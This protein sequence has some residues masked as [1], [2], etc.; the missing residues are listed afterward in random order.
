MNWV[1]VKRFS[2]TNDFEWTFPSATLRINGDYAN[3]YTVWLNRKLTGRTSCV[4]SVGEG[5]AY[6]FAK[7]KKRK[8]KIYTALLT[9]SVK[10]NT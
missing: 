1:V 2:A 6:G 5:F 9:A 10:T 7:K 8:L 3:Q 4:C